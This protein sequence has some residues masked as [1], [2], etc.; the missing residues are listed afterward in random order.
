[1]A[2]GW[3]EGGREVGRGIKDWMEIK[4]VAGRERER[5]KDGGWERK[6]NRDKR[7]GERMREGDGT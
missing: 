7:E 4:R 1:M 2:E 3:R 6:I 5:E